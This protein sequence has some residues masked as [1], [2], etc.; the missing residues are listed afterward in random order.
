M[1]GCAFLRQ[2][3][4]NR[5]DLHEVE[6]SQ[7]IRDRHRKLIADTVLHLK[8]FQS[9]TIITLRGTDSLDWRG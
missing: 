3:E 1:A 7:F 6:D 2:G 4:Y 9:S 8:K 5:G